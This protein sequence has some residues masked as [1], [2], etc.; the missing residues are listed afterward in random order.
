LSFVVNPALLW[1]RY[2]NFSGDGTLR[3]VMAVANYQGFDLDACKLVEGG[4]GDDAFMEWAETYLIP[5]LN[6]F[7]RHHHRINSILILDNAII[8]WSQEFLDALAETGAL[9]IH[10]APYSPDMSAIELCFHQMKETLRRDEQWARE[11]PQAALTHALA[12]VS[13]VNME[14]CFRH[15]C[16]APLPAE[17]SLLPIVD[18]DVFALEAAL[19]ILPTMWASWLPLR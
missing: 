10:L 19:A 8:H 7:D 13:Q 15:C 18:E 4:V 5:M 17:L 16:Y 6:P 3:T 11:D 9:V 1:S 14:R 2:E 12:S